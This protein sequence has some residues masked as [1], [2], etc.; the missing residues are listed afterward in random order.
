VDNTLVA[1][2][3][4]PVISMSR[5]QRHRVVFDWMMKR[6]EEIPARQALESILEEIKPDA[7]YKTLDAV[8]FAMSHSEDQARPV[9]RASGAHYEYVN[10]AAALRNEN[11][12]ARALEESL[13]WLGVVERGICDGESC[14]R[15]SPLG[16]VLLRGKP[17]ST[18]AQ[19]YQEFN[20][21]L[22]V[23]PN[24]DIVV[25]I[26]DMDPL[27][28]VPLDQFG[29]RISV[30]Q[31]AVYSLT[32]ESFVQAVQNGHNASAFIDFLMRHNRGHSLPS[33]VMATLEDWGGAIKRVRIKTYHVIE[34]DDPL[35]M[36]DLVHRRK[37]AKFFETIDAHKTVRYDGIVRT[38]LEKALEKEGFIV[39]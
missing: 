28:T 11:K 16:E 9:L 25:P 19:R 30:G 24:F 36:A 2:D 18:V 29:V 21:E 34:S 8:S 20:A 3:L 10:P 32:K 6:P 7:W 14:F 35:V 22:V 33:N 37:F 23:Q 4:E 5:T 1:H 27:L 31:V 15:I 12:L 26:Q 38:D 17:E 13:F 39:E